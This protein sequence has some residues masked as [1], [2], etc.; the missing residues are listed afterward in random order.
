MAPSGNY[1]KM[2]RVSIPGV[3]RMSHSALA[4][5]IRRL[6]GK[7]ASQQGDDSD[8]QLLNTFAVHRDDN[9]FGV[10]VRR[11]GPMVL[12]VCR[13]VLEHEQDAEDAFQATFL[14]LARQAALLRNKT[15]VAS[16]LH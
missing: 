1:R 8:E 15:A 9:A 14:V 7:L 3:A 2:T 4:A 6:R 5:G 16:F 10:L 13:R 12:Y 11:H